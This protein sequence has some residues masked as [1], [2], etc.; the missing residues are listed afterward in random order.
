MLFNEFVPSRAAKIEDVRIGG[1]EPV[2]RQFSLRYCQIVSLGFNSGV[3]AGSGARVML[4]GTF[5]LR[6]TCQP[7]RS[8]SSTACGPSPTAREISARCRAIASVV[9][10]D[11]TRPEAL[12]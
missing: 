7:A 1:E 6:E 12:P 4:G 11:S 9:Q 8:N 10:R 5:S 3:L 2:E